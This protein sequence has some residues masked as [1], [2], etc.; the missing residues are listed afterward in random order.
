MV[1][2]ILLGLVV[3]FV[4]TQAAAAV[5]KCMDKA[6]QTI[7]SGQPCASNAEEIKVRTHTPSADEVARAQSEI[8]RIGGDLENSSRE[9]EIESLEGDIRVK[10]KAMENEL[11]VLRARQETANNNLAGA[12][13][14]AGIATEMQAV[15]ARY[16]GEIDS[17][18]QQIEA[19]KSE[20]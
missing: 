3:A 4:S 7:F 13:Y 14:Y 11:R 2:A 16:Q 12:Q 6:G 5:Y 17:L 20:K 1:R 10:R 19:L 18:R 9:R 8:S 15:T